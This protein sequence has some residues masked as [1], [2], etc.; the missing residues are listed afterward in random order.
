MIRQLAHVCFYSDRIDEM[1]RFYN[2]ILGL[3]IKFTLDLSDGDSFGYYFACGNTTFIEI[4]DRKKALLQWGGNPSDLSKG[5]QYKHL[6]FEVKGLAGF[7][8]KLLKQGISVSEI[9]T[10]MDFSSQAWIN[11]PDGNSIELMEYSAKSLQ[12]L[13]K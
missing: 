3:N 4:F 13:K 10:G 12:L 2:Q 7:K 8:E 5:N 11:D 9:T 6:C 1:V